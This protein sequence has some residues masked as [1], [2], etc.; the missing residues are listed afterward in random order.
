MG[1]SP[2]FPGYGNVPFV[3]LLMLYTADLPACTTWAGK[4]VSVLAGSDVNNIRT[5]NANIEN[6]SGQTMM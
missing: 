5:A 6:N 1:N 3:C 4:Y 2:V